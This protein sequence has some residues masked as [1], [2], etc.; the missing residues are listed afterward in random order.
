MKCINLFLFVLISSCA[1]FEKKVPLLKFDKAQALKSYVKQALCDTHAGQSKLAAK[2]GAINAAY[3]LKSTPDQ[4]LVGFEAAKGEEILIIDQ[5][6]QSVSGTFY[7]NIL[8]FWHEHKLGQANLIKLKQ[9]LIDSAE[10]YRKLLEMDFTACKLKFVDQM[11]IQVSCAKHSITIN[12]NLIQLTHS[13][14]EIKIELKDQKM[15][16]ISWLYQLND[17]ALKM[18]Q[19]VKQCYPQ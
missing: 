19:L 10:Y 6:G 16:Q 8:N 5:A 13:L 1:L 3:S 14:G 7:Q 15:R 2:A 18:T 12:S 11:Q 17:Q 4:M 9:A